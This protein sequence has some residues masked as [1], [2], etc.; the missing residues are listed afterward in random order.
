MLQHLLNAKEQ[1]ATERSD[2]ARREAS[3]RTRNAGLEVSPPPRT[4]AIPSGSS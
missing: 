2:G 4:K 3:E 1:G